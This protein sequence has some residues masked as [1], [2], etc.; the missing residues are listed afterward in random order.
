[1]IERKNIMKASLIFPDA[2]AAKKAGMEQV[3]KLSFTEEYCATS[4]GYPVFQLPNEEMLD[5]EK[6]RNLRDNYGAR[7]ETN[8][9]VKV[10]MGIGIPR[11]EPGVVVVD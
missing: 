8:I 7:L 6:F 3:T 2:E 10:C 11:D 5:C 1:M 9:L 4:F